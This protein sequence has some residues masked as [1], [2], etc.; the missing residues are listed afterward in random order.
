MMYWVTMW[1]NAQSTVL[2]QPAIYAKNITLRYPLFIPFSGNKIRITFD[3]F[4]CKERIILDEIYASIGDELS[5][6]AMIEGIP[7]TNSFKKKFVIE[8]GKSITSDPLDFVREEGK[9]LILSIYI[10]DYTNLT[11]GVDVIGPLS[12]GYF[13]YGNQALAKKLDINLSKSTSWVYFLSNVDVYTED[14][15]EAIICYGDSIT[16]QDWPD[17]FLLALREAG[18]KNRS[19]IRKAVSG[20]RIL[21]EY[22]C[23]TYQSYGKN[24]FHRFEHEVSSVSG[25]KTIIVQHGIN[26]II[27]PVGAE[28]NPFRPMSDLP[29][30]KELISGLQFYEQC[31]FKLGL[32]LYFGTLLPIYGWRTYQPFRENLKNEVNHW[33]R[34]RKNVDF[35]AEL[36]SYRDYHYEFKQGYDSGDHL[37]PSKEAYQRMGKLMA[38]RIID[39]L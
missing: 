20:T 39:D 6:E 30:A 9:Y 4:C 37:H 3:N 23:I 24:G 16:S 29:T 25:A 33:I 10:K 32:D 19:V 12:K 28:L 21:R 31:A 26:D 35:E 36:A 27:H 1:G 17:Y 18:I 11:S 22:S 7:I 8:A 2:P 38:Q 14:H 13:S 5:D 15:N 34:E